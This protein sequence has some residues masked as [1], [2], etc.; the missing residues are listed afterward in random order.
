MDR[1]K[2]K[3]EINSPDPGYEPYPVSIMNRSTHEATTFDPALGKPASISYRLNKSGCIRVRIVH[4]SQPDLLIRT[5][6]DWTPQGF[7][8]YVLAWDGRDASGNIVDNKGIQVLFESKDRDG[9]RTHQAHEESAC[10]DPQIHVRT[11]PDSSRP[12]KGRLEVRAGI[13]GTDG[14]FGRDGLEARCYVDYKPAKTETAAAGAGEFVFRIDT[15][16]LENG[17]HLVTVNIF[18]LHDHRGTAGVRI[19]VEN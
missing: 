12:V 1:E 19:R 10:R 13:V 2:F 6:Q 5:L 11:D 18:D 14:A 15:A 7:G 9:G 4:R 17:D 16:G 3:I 8:R